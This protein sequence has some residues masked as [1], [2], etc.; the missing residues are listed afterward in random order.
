MIHH[1][2]DRSCIHQV[3]KDDPAVTSP[4][5]MDDGSMIFFNIV[6][7]KNSG[8]GLYTA[9]SIYFSCLYNNMPGPSTGGMGMPMDVF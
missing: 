6:S 4:I 3:A 7:N 5:T 1:K 2:D 8:L 9:G